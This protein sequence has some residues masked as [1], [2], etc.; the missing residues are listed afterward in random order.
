[1]FVLFATFHGMAQECPKISY[2]RNEATQIGV[3]AT[4]TWPSVPGVVGYLISLGTSP[5]GVDILNQRSAGL[6]NSFTPET[7]LP[8][9]TIIYVTISMFLENQQLKVC[10]GEFFT[11][12]DVTLPPSCTVL[13]GAVA[14][15]T[16]VRV[17]EKITWDYAPTATGYRL[18]LGTTAGNYDL[19]DNLDVGNALD[20]RLPGNLPLDQDIFIRLVPYNENGDAT[21]CAEDRF[22]TG[23]PTV[24]CSDKK[25]ANDIP[26]QLGIC[27]NDLPTTIS[28]EVFASG[29][30]WFKLAANG[31]ET[32]V[33]E[34]REVALKDIG[35]YRL[36]TYNNINDAGNI[37]ECSNS[38][39]FEVVLSKAP[40]ISS[41]DVRREGGGLRIQ[42]NT[43][44]SGD[45]E[46]A[47]DLENGNYQDSP[48]FEN[49]SDAEHTV[50]V[51]DRYGCGTTQRIV[52]E[53]L[54]R[55]N[56][57]AYFTPNGDG[58]N[59]FWQFMPP[60]ESGEI[61]VEKIYIFDQYG[62]FL[63]QLDPRSKGWGGTQNGRPLPSSDYWYRAISFSRK[64]IKGHFT[65]KR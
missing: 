5:G 57:P 39:T 7:G 61:N 65:L 34:T 50:F 2:P 45:Y 12:V 42:V 60:P 55:K 54:S 29:F 14:G 25:P 20:Y 33:S 30:R 59:D 49:V 51:R 63:V 64:E 26:D 48:I 53:S 11:T 8:D 35:R 36:E 10:P 9:D 56:F 18:S 46:Y 28:T 40:I 41:V 62:N 23:V 4:I 6:T 27:A 31:N 37:I 16:A 43:K 1:M 58:I 22:S 52:E 24:D 38:K 44:G 17:N 3:D 21:P 13:N 15:N 32:L 19:V 47:L